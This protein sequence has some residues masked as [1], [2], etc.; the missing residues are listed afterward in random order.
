MSDKTT[1]FEYQIQIL[2][3]HLD[4]FGHVN[5]ATYLEI[6]EEARWDFITE[7]GYGL[8][9]IK[10]SKIGPVILNINISFKKEILNR[11]KIIIKSQYK[12][13][14]NKLVM[15]ISQQMIKENGDIASEILLDIGVMDLQKRKLIPPHAEWL[16]AV[17]V[18]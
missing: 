17:G 10:S 9:H 2:E 3:N 8:A 4:T 7:N 16:H 1:D 12:G 6:Y 14:V 11:E 18:N 13:M 5:N 15:Q